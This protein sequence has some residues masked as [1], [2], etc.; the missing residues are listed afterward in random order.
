MLRWSIYVE[1]LSKSP[2][3]Y[4]KFWPFYQP[5]C[6][7]ALIVRSEVSRPWFLYS[8]CSNSSRRRSVWKLFLKNK[9]YQ[10]FIIHYL[11]NYTVNPRFCYI[12]LYYISFLLVDLK[13]HSWFI[14]M[15]YWFGFVTFLFCYLNFLFHLS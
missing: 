2:S 6:H 7:G 5:P 11:M 3:F 15:L 8:S 14:S 10:A 1:V 4:F 12:L 13:I 9:I